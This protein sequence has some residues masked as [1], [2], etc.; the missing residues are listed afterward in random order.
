MHPEPQFSPQATQIEKLLVKGRH[1]SFVVIPEDLIV[2]LSMLYYGE[3]H[4]HEWQFVKRFLKPSQVIVDAGANLGTFTVPFAKTV[5]E[6]GKVIS[7]EPQPVIYGC[8]KETVA[9]NQLTNV[10]LHH[11]C[12]GNG[13]Y[14]LEIAEPDYSQPGNFSGVPFKEEGFTEVKFSPNRIRTQC[15]TLDGV[16]KDS[17][18]DFLKIDVEGMELEVLQGAEKSIASRKPVIY[19]ENN[20]PQKSPPIIAF[21]QKHGY[22][23]WWHTGPFF[24]PNNFSR[25]DKNIYGAMHN[26][27]NICLPPG[28]DESLIP[29]SMRPVTDVND[30][31]KLASDRIIPSLADD[32][33]G[34]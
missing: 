33:T 6:L 5:G 13:D 24:N 30:H 19:L 31:I 20:R 10:E 23:M 15:V 32:V 14:E 8:L 12:V 22:R 11:C 3:Y 29:T 28:A 25:N 21:L 18:F 26:I 1:G 7:F 9:L 4:E 27:N 2:S 16:L 34:V 17:R